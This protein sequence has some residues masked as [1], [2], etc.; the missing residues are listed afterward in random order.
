MT[1]EG[2]VARHPAVRPHATKPAIGEAE[3]DFIAQPPLASD[4]HAVV[5][6]QHPH[7]RLVSSARD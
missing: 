4:T 1:R 5:D 2:A 6:D 7:Q 3:V